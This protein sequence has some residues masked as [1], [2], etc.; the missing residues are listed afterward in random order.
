MI[1]YRWFTIV[2]PTT[3]NQAEVNWE[4]ILDVP[5]DA[6]QCRCACVCMPMCNAFSFFHL[7]S[8]MTVIAGAHHYQFKLIYTRV[9]RMNWKKMMIVSQHLLSEAWLLLLP[10]P[11]ASSPRQLWLPPHGKRCSPCC[12][13]TWMSWQGPISLIWQSK[14]GNCPY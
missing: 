7:I 1:S 12:K 2:V 3:R 10:F 14:H 11:L 9:W 6:I 4:N 5:V 8:A 13:L